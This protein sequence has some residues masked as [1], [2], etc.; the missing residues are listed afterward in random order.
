[1]QLCYDTSFRVV[2]ERRALARTVLMLGHLVEVDDVVRV[3]LDHIWEID[4][5]I[6]KSSVSDDSA[7][8]EFM[9]AYLLDGR[10]IVRFREGP[11]GSNLVA[12]S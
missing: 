2:I 4:I 7:I 1:M 6:C 3:V 12:S 11:R 9:S 10:G 8:A 5:D